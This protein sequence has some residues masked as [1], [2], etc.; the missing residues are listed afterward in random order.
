[1]V[2]VDGFNLF[3]GALKG[4][5]HRWLDLEKLFLR[6]RQD[7]DLVG[8]RYFTAMVDGQSREDQL[9]YL[10][11]LQAACPLIEVELGLFKRTEVKCRVRGCSYPGDRHFRKPEEKRTD[12]KIALA[13]LDDAY[14]DRCDRLVLVSGDS[15][16]V[17]AIHMVRGRFPEKRVIVYVPTR[18]PSRGGAVEVRGAATQAR[19]LPLAL[20]PR[21]QLPPS[22]PGDGDDTHAK[23]AGW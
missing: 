16:L 12:V 2:Y 18:H 8:I 23:P 17:P 6:I 22:V 1:M 15:D 4:T 9:T 7:D 13:M 5:D 11:A 21:C 14:R 3:Y 10:S 20:L 19:N